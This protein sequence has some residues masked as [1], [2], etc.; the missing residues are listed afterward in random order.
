MTLEQ[1]REK[2]FAYALEQGCDAAETYFEEGDSFSVNARDGEID[3]YS[4]SRRAGLSLRVQLNGSD[5]Y[6]YTEALEDPEQLV[7]RA[8]DNA[9]IIESKDDHPMQGCCSYVEVE[10]APHAL[11]TATEARKI[12]LAL[13]MEQH[14]RKAD[15]RVQRVVHCRV[16][17]ARGHIEIH[18]TCGL[19]AVRD[20]SIGYCYVSP[21]L[22]EGGEVKTGFAVRMGKEATQAA[23]CAKAA[24]R[25]A[26]EKFGASPVPS[27]EYRILLKTE[28]A[29]DLFEGFVPMFS[30]D[31][32]Q[33]GCSLLAGKEGQRIGAETVTIVDDPFHPVAPRAFDGEGTPCVKKTVVEAGVLKTLLHN[34]KTAK[35]AG[36]E[37][38]GNASRASAASAVGIGPTVM[39]VQPGTARYA[40][41]VRLLNNGL[42]ITSI[43]G[44][45]A[46][47]DTIS[48]DFSLKA[49][50]FLVEDGRIVRPVSQITVAGNFVRL[51]S[52]VERVGGDLRFQ[53][54]SGGFAA[55]PSLL[56]RALMVAGE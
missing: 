30:A 22:S 40:N 48:G 42:I 5:G 45:H 37:S 10:A 35:K 4:V 43:E 6:A 47:L 1:F 29:S 7:L 54:G 23:A 25:D 55:S 8:M 34:L 9:K 56:V 13:D 46:G 53:F 50:G 36:V 28:A 2:A 27:G 20:E 21:L 33:K 31:E 41:L 24:V 12:K 26:A 16:G 17:T 49:E 15:P 11:E 3:R 38:T 51:L 44:L 18:N 19:A 52:D 14:A 32:A 39:Y